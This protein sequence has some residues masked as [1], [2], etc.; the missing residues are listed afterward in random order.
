MVVVMLMVFTVNVLLLYAAGQLLGGRGNLLR[1]AGGALLG[2]VFA[3]FS[4]VPG[5][6]F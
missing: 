1:I 5:F 3:A 4:M 6:Q 2:A